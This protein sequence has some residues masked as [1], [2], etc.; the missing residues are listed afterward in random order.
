MQY[1]GGKAKLAKHITPILE[2]ALLLS[3]GSFYEPFVGGFNIVP[4]IKSAFSAAHCSDSHAGLINMWQAVK[5]G[6]EPPSH[7]TELDYAAIRLLNDSN[8]PIT[9]FVAFG[10]S[11]GGK[12]WG[13]MARNARGDNY[14]DRARRSVLHKA[15]CMSRVTF[16][17]CDYRMVTPENAVI[18]ADPPYKGTTGY[19][20][21]AFNHSE[22]YEWC[23]ARA[24]AN[25]I[26]V[27][28]FTVP[29]REG[30]E[31]VLDL[32]RKTSVRRNNDEVVHDYLI[33]VY[34]T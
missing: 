27:S 26:F 23:E 11:F 22:F 13:G 2:D 8:D 10:V 16:T 19:A 24:A 33:R 28:E 6:W 30:W 31:V 32:P 20:N 3:D 7:V 29:D 14:A 21:G 1:L 18:Y 12:E 25:A 4:R 15:R 17:A 34:P 5:N 9:A